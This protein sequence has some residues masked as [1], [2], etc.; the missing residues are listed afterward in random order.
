MFSAVI[1]CVYDYKMDFHCP[2]VKNPTAPNK[3]G[4]AW[5]L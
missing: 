2:L 4:M 1:K 5:K 3:T